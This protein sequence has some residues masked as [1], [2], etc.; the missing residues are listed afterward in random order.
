MSLAPVPPPALPL[1]LSSYADQISLFSD[2]NSSS[3]SCSSTAAEESLDAALRYLYAESGIPAQ[4]HHHAHLQ[5]EELHTI[6]IS[7]KLSLFNQLLTVR[8]PSPPLPHDVLGDINTVFAF[9]PRRH[10]LTQLDDIPTVPGN[11]KISVWK[12]DIT[13]L[14]GVTA[15]VN[16]ANSRLLGCFRPDHPCIDNAIHAA[17]SP[18]LRKDCETIIKLQGGEEPTGEVKV[19]RG[20]FLPARFVLHTVGPIVARKRPSENQAAELAR[21]YS[22]CLE[23]VETLPAGNEMSI[24][25][26]CISTG[27]FGYPADQ[28]ADIAIST[29]TDYL[30]KNPASKVQRVIFNVFTEDDLALYTSRLSPSAPLVQPAQPLPPTVAAAIGMLSSADALLITAGAGLSASCG[31]D[32]TSRS[33]FS[34]HFPGMTPRGLTCFYDV[35]GY[36]F[37]NELEKW[38]YYFAHMSTVMNWPLGTADAYCHVKTLI[39][40]FT[41]DSWFV[42]TSNAD[43]LFSR[44]G[45]DPD[46]ISTPQGDYRYLQCARRC[47]P[48]AV[49]AS[50]QFQERARPHLDARQQILRDPAAIPKCSYCGG[51]MFLCVRADEYFN[52]KPFRAGNQRY[53]EFLAR[54]KKQGKKLVVLE[55]GAGWNTPAVLRWPDQSLVE[56]GDAQALVRIGIKGDEEVPWELMDGEGEMT[57][58]VGING[59]ATWALGAIV[60]G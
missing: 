5:V 2:C 35:F 39:S 7:E 41:T 56:N 26:C 1:D 50:A 33:L 43:G 34:E 29:V 36:N 32:Y 60:R 42:R 17:A 13:K 54:V 37:P 16:A 48:D 40:R 18:R 31:L 30:R 55:I 38:G 8:P 6:E 44:H 12:G 4:R 27:M 3:V 20:Y 24:A 25:F 49:F 21:C 59:D 58:A 45:I 15:I 11:E 28:A 22:R 19:T 51:N 23:A 46:H 53:R 14:A 57:R 47:S 9:L 10:A 52:D